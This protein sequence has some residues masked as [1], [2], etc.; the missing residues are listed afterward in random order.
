MEKTIW[1]LVV[2]LAFAGATY[3]IKSSYSE[4]QDSP[5]ATNIITHPLN[6]LDFPT[7]TVCPPE[8][9]YTPLYPD[10]VKVDNRSLSDDDRKELLKSINKIVKT[11]TMAFAQK[12]L[13]VTN[14]E[15]SERLFQGYQ[16]FPSKYEDGFEIKVGGIEGSIKSPRFRKKY[17]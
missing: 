12:V 8:K 11:S 9:S 7:V 16:S 1:V 13:E 3:L 14:P 6:D 15:N 4:W 2:I 5:I 10:L 17:D